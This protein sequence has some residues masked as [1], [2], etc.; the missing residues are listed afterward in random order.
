MMAP[1]IDVHHH[2]FPAAL[3]AALAAAGVERIGG[4]PAPRSWTPEESLRLMDRQGIDAA[5]LSLPIP[6][7]AVR[8]SRRA[9]LARAINEFGAECVR[10]RPARFGFLAALPLPDVDAALEELRHALDD[11]GADGVALL[12]NHGGIYPGDR[13]LDPLYE[14]LDRR[15]AVV[16]LH[17]TMPPDADAPSALEL[18]FETTRAVASLLV[19]RRLDRAPYVR[20][21]VTH[22]G[23]TTSLAEPDIQEIVGVMEAAR[24]D[25]PDQLEALHQDA[26]LSSDARVL[27]ALIG[28]VPPGSLLLGTDLPMARETGVHVT[29]GGIERL[30]ELAPEARDGVRATNAARLFPRLAAAHEGRV[31]AA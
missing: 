31:L 13:R 16:F 9:R 17:P 3:M 4:E 14:E 28:L 1:V 27:C 12:T 26:A 29:L 25:A 5:I 10:R 24:R 7:A 19:S 23:R 21:I 11:L 8:G 6:L 20:H 15:G 18:P 22:C 2:M 30:D